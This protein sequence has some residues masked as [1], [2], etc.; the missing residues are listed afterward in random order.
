METNQEESGV[1]IDDVAGLLGNDTDEELIE[2]DEEEEQPEEESEELE[3][4]ESEEDDSEEVE[5]EGKSYKVPKELKDMVLMHKDYTQKTQAVADQ[6]KAVEERSQAL[7]HRERMLG[8]TFEKAVAFR[9]VQSKLA[10]YENLDWNSLAASDPSRAMQLNLAFQQLQREAQAKHGEWQQASTEAEHLTSTQ[11][12]QQLVEAEKD[13]LVRLPGFGPQLAEKIVSNATHYG[14]S[15]DELG[16]LTDPRAVHVLHDAMKWRALQ[17]GKPTQ[18]QKVA[19][20]PKAI[21]PQAAQPKRSHQ[22]A[23]DRLRSSGRVEDL[24]AFL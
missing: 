1:S 4:D 16:G 3:P 9:E 8:Q 22:A 14:F 17:A 6:R 10:Q 5:I 2:E 18:M 24:A 7:E 13:L 12:Q 21:K 11:R 19:N 20:A 15:K 23:T